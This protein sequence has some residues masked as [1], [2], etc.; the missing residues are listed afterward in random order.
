MCV[1]VCV[2]VCV[3]VCERNFL[4][5]CVF[6]LCICVHVCWNVFV[7]SLRVLIFV[8]ELMPSI[9]MQSL[10]QYVFGYVCVRL[11]I[12]IYVCVCVRVCV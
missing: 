3:S 8:Y 1:C 12:Y 5:A 11:H 10:Q 2:C 4:H 7:L 9:C 6:V